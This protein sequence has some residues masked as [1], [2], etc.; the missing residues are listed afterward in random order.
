MRTTNATQAQ[1][2][3]IGSDSDCS[4]TERSKLLPFP[5]V[6]SRVRVKLNFSLKRSMANKLAP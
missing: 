5:L 4:V 6:R 2:E 1:K 3:H